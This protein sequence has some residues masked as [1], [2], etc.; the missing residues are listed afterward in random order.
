MEVFVRKESG[1]KV[2]QIFCIAISSLAILLA[3]VGL[4]GATIWKGSSGEWA[5]ISLLPAFIFNLPVGLIALVIGFV[6]R[7]GV[8]RLRKISIATSVIALMS[9]FLAALLAK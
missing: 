9:P 2:L 6:A 8:P 1:G 4:G 3:L 7:G 5:N